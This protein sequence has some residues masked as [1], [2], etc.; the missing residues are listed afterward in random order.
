MTAHGPVLARDSESIRME[1][2]LR[3]Y[4]HFPP[5]EQLH[6]IREHEANESSQS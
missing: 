4:G 2:W 3:E 5:A 1:W 6:A